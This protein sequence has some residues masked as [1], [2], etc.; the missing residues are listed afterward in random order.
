MAHS[1]HGVQVDDERSCESILHRGDL[2]I[3]SASVR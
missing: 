1:R 3:H 2:Q